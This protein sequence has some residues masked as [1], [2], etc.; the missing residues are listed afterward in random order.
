MDF[1]PLPL[2]TYASSFEVLIEN[3][4]DIQYDGGDFLTYPDRQGWTERTVAE[5]LELFQNPSREFTRFME[6][7][8]LFGTLHYFFGGIIEPSDLIRFVENPRRLVLSMQPLCSLLELDIYSGDLAI[9]SIAMELHLELSLA[10]NDGDYNEYDLYCR[11]D[12]ISGIR[13]KKFKDPRSP[14]MVF[15]TSAW[16]EILMYW[17]IWPVPVEMGVLNLSATHK[18]IIWK[19]LRGQDW[20]PSDLTGALHR[21]NSSSL[22]FLHAISQPTF[23]T[24][25]HKMIH[26]RG[27]GRLPESNPGKA[28]PSGDLCNPFVCGLNKLSD[29]DYATKHARGCSGC[30]NIQ[31]DSQIL[32]SILRKQ[33]VPLIYFDKAGSICLVE[34]EPE[35][36]YIAISHVWS[37]GLGNPHANALPYCQIDRL[38]GFV[39][40][41]KCN[42]CPNLLFW[43]DTICVPPDSASLKDEQDSAMGLMREVY[44]Q[45]T[46]VLVL[47]SWLYGSTALDK[48]PVEN[49]MRIF[50]SRW[51]SRLWTYQ[52]GV[53]AKSLYFQFRDSSVELETEIQRL[54][55]GADKVTQLTLVQPLLRMYQEIRFLGRGDASF[56]EKFKAI[57]SSLGDRNTSVASDEPLCIGTLLGLN[58]LQ[59]AQAPPELRMQKLWKMIPLVPFSFLQ[60][61]MV[62]L[63]SPGL[64]WAP[65]T[66]LRCVQNRNRTGNPSCWSAS[67]LGAVGGTAT[68]SDEGVILKSPGLLFKPGSWG[69]SY[70]EIGPGT[71]WHYKF[72]FQSGGEFEDIGI[73]LLPKNAPISKDLS[74]DAPE[75]REGETHALLV[76]VQKETTEIVHCQYISPVSWTE[77]TQK[78]DIEP[79]N[80]LIR[81]GTG[82]YDD[83]VRYETPDGVLVARVGKRKPENQDWCIG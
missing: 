31:A 69:G 32:C 61:Q 66:F 53:L 41:L 78:Q 56:E 42:G 75:F 7:W 81:P 38:N 54:K 3:I 83:N 71:G 64:S 58:V 29:Q 11:M 65:K 49:L 68:V 21:F 47:D 14:E 51:T 22:Y 30:Y 26:I 34:K 44:E 77:L 62:R 4:Q 76:A 52:E 19:L 79:L 17:T 37:D 80:Q 72:K 70:E 24:K 1:L 33:K 39:R 45:A 74:P 2:G 48:W 50:S 12:L 9:P 13:R 27:R 40:N 82:F 60:S 57:C 5:W 55:D 25:S 20:C 43:I 16:L 6:R 59:L 18:S 35:M 36:S 8:I 63:E 46:A 23:A 10:E 28:L 73:I 67:M 15:V